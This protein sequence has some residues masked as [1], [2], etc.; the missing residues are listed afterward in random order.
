MDGGEALTEWKA[1]VRGVLTTALGPE[2]GIVE[3]FVELRFRYTGAQWT[4]MDNSIFWKT[5]HAQIR[6]ACG[7]IAAAV[8]QLELELETD[9]PVDEQAFDPELW[10][11]V[12]ALVEDEDW[13]KVASQTAIFVESHVRDWAGDPKD[14]NGEGLVGKGLY[15]A[16]FADDSD[17]R[18]GARA[19]EREGWRF[20]GMG[21]AQAV[22]NVDRH[23]IQRRDDARRYAV[24]VLG[25]GSLLLTQLRWEHAELI[26]DA[27]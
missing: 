15:A 16:V 21:F 7:L 19:G 17:W 12:R 4:G 5:R 20:L 1:K 25:L 22:G 14:K 11:F 8:H 6:E 13:G 9:E 27:L 10:A 24:G 23:K 3:R 18:L 26:E 2:D